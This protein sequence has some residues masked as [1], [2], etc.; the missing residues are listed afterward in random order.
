[1][2]P[3]TINAKTEISS[4]RQSTLNLE[5]L[6]ASEH[7]PITSQKLKRE[8]GKRNNATTISVMNS[9]RDSQQVASHT[10]Y[11]PKFRALR[12]NDQSMCS[13][14]SAGKLKSFAH[15]NAESKSAT[16]K[17]MQSRLSAKNQSQKQLKQA[18]T[19]DGHELAVKTPKL[20]QSSANKRKSVNPFLTTTNKVSNTVTNFIS[21]HPSAA[22]MQEPPLV[23]GGLDLTYN[24][25]RYQSRL[26]K[27]VQSL[28]QK[29][30]PGKEKQ[31]RPGQQ[32]VKEYYQLKRE[33]DRLR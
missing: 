12:M 4:F 32:Q 31:L 14:S 28:Q 9:S 13:H 16:N 27:K 19:F 11:Q 6:P 8:G 18:G 25:R 33:H 10:P 17:S 22:G 26:A 30:P 2:P 29:V 21:E 15:A 7:T 20:H 24:E 23:I 1:M 5:H 3:T